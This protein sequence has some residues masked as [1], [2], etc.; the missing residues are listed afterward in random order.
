MTDNNIRSLVVGYPGTYEG[1][2]GNFY[3]PSGYQAKDNSSTMFF[4]LMDQSYVG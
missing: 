3:L 2:G 4:F 1:I